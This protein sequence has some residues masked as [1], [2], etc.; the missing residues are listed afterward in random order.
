MFKRVGICFAITTLVILSFLVFP[1]A[2][3]ANETSISI[4]PLIFDLSANPGDTV[5]NE[6]LIRN[7][8]A[9]PTVVSVEALDFVASGEEG[10][11][12][13]T[14]SQSTYSLA[15]WIELDSNQ[16]TLKGGEQTKV[17]FSIRVPF[18]AEP[19]GH[20]ASVYVHLSPTLENASSGSG[21]GQK[22]GSLI[23]MKVA[24]TTKEGAEAETFKTTKSVYENGPVNFNI[25]IK[26]TGSVHVKPKGIIAITDIFG[27]KVADVAVE[28]KNILPGAVRHTTA[29]WEKTPKFGKYTATLLSYYGSD[30][31]LLTTATTFW[32]IPWKT[33]AV[34][35][36]VIILLIVLIWLGRGRLKNAGKALLNK[37]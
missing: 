12:N 35:A 4:S 18:N 2:K 26:N 9:E 28:Q 22:I 29:T 6:L 5:T 17:K 33:F 37:K 23:L 16:F 27:K 11:I 19:G 32:I 24:G 31:K 25:R 21:V 8:G 13:L 34:I 14:D 10:E 3:A 20:Y 15:S 1:Y 36:A 30:N 7:S